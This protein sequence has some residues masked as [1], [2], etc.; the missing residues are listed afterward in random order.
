MAGESERLGASFSID[1]S[2]LKAGLAQANRLIRESN[3]EFKSAAAG[4]DDWTASEEG[5]TAKLKNLNT[6]ADLQAK[7]VAALQSEYDRMVSEGLDPASASAIKLRT[8]INKEQEALNK[9]TSEIAEH[10]KKLKLIQRYGADGAKELEELGKATKD[11]GDSFT[12]AKGAIAGFIANGLTSLVGAC[13]N[14]I[15]SVLGLAD[16]TKETRTAFAKLDQSFASAGLGAENA[17]KTITDLYGV[18]GNMDK[19]TEASN[20]LAK[21]SKDENDLQK[22]TRILSGVFAEYGESIPTEGLAEAMQ[23]TSAMSSVQGVLADAL[24][25]QGV[26]LDEFNESLGTMSTAEERSAYI[27]ETLTKLYG[28]AA[29]S[30]RKNNKNLIEANEAQLAYEKTLGILGD[31]VEPIT[32]KIREG[33]AKILDKVLELVEGVDFEAF[34]AK[35]EGAFDKFVNETMPKI[36]DALA[37]IKDNAPYIEAGIAGIGAAMLTLAIADKINAVVKSFRAFKAAQEGATVAQW[38]LNAALNA[39]PIGLVV[40]AVT[41]LIAVF[42]VLWNKCEGF[43]KFWGDMWAGFKKVAVVALNGLIGYINAWIKGLNTIMTPLRGIIYG[44][45]K[46][47][48]SNISFDDVKIPEIPKIALA[49]GGVVNKATSAVIGENGKEAVIPL[50]K[51]TEWMDIL[52]EKLASKSGA[53]VVNQT[54]NYSQ[55]HSRYEIYKSKQQTAAAVRLAMQ[56]VK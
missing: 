33:F 29:D 10:N 5:L 17:E 39:N 44:V 23:A 37:W 9:A 38:L 52:A 18:L 49:K 47:F 27:Q 34:A 48:G 54:N 50:E 13:K 12:V 22:N 16:S 56:G 4:M 53:V 55:A 1:V 41:G 7:K 45:A 51:N 46:A 30:Y 40:A 24:E 14:A 25:W 6:V 31:K 35:V 32:T 20:L 3:S 36:L 26:N 21:M 19:A 28:E 15:S 8:D 43:R 2:A 42:A 11:A